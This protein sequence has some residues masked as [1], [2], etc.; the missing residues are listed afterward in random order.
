VARAAE[1]GARLEARKMELARPAAGCPRAR[2]LPRSA[3]LAL[4]RVTPFFFA[5]LHRAALESP[6]TSSRELHLRWRTW[7]GEQE[8]GRGSRGR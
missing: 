6:R 1:L 8:G 7:Q 5:R 3:E 2:A 4:H